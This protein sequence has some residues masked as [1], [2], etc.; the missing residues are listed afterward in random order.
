MKLSLPAEFS[1]LTLK[2]LMILNSSEDPV[3]WIAEC[4]NI[5]T[6]E[7]HSM[8]IKLYDKAKAH[9]LQ[10]L[11]AES[12]THPITMI[13][14]GVEYGFIPSWAEFTTGEWIDIEMW[15]DDFWN[16]ADK[17][18][19]LLYRP[20][21]SK[22]GSRYEIEEYT[23]KEDRTIFHD[24]SASYFAG[25]MLFFWTSRSRLLSDTRTSL[26]KI[27]EAG[28]MKLEPNGD[29]TMDSTTSRMRTFSKWMRSRLSLLKS[30]FNTS[31]TSVTYK[32]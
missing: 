14:N 16:N 15:G 26:R 23:A 6:K 24:L 32:T 13:H 7:V 28:L 12:A 25:A 2:G 21:T 8:P 29:G 10:L 22:L 31:A 4:A 27:A 11:E 30:Y 3:Q 5:T 17:I 20:I 9:L 1:D 18:M 19:A